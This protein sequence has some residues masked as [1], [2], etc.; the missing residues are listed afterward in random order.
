MKILF[1]LYT[2]VILVGSVSAAFSQSNDWSYDFD[3][4]ERHECKEEIFFDDNLN[5]KTEVVV[6]P[7]VAHSDAVELK[8][9]R[10]RCI[11]DIDPAYFKHQLIVEAT[12]VV[13][14]KSLIEAYGFTA[15]RG[16]EKRHIIWL[17]SPNLMQSQKYV[18]A[19]S[20]TSSLLYN[21]DDVNF[22]K[23][24]KL[25]MSCNRGFE[26]YCP[27]KEKTIYFEDFGNSPNPSNVTLSSVSGTWYD[28]AYNGMGFNVVQAQN[29]L[30][31]YFYGY[32][33]ETDGQTQWLLS[34]VGPN[35]IHKGQKIILPMYA[36][37]PGNGGRFDTKPTASDSGVK[38][39]GNAE[40]MFNSCS[41]GVIKLIGAD[42]TVTHNVVKLVG[43]N[44]LVCAE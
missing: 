16:E 10:R 34:G 20:D 18:A 37:F 26:D 1:K 5:L 14:G 12:P 21:P 44:G 7:D 31:V 36:G 13:K 24:F 39:W 43:I 15:Y 32:K 19:S 3:R 8:F 4:I 38:P 28:P 6:I 27:V 9:S 40:L 35:L 22:S 42:G 11:D 23:A 29:G 2:F 30:F 41:S 25:V 33:K 17:M